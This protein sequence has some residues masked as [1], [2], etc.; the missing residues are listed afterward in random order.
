VE[1]KLKGTLIFGGGT[2]AE[3]RPQP[4]CTESTGE[5]LGPSL[6]DLSVLDPTTTSEESEYWGV[7][8]AELAPRMSAAT[9]LLHTYELRR[10]QRLSA[11]SLGAGG[12]GAAA[13]CGLFKEIGESLNICPAATPAKPS[14]VL[15]L[16]EGCL[17]LGTYQ[18]ARPKPGWSAPFLHRRD[19]T[20]QITLRCCDVD[21][22]TGT[23]APRPGEEAL[24]QFRPCDFVCMATLK[25]RE[26]AAGEVLELEAEGLE[27]WREMR[28]LLG[29]EPRSCLVASSQG[30]K[31]PG[32]RRRACRRQRARN[33]RA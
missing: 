1:G 27:R 19:E 28:V 15:V 21:V 16:H 26:S 30:G 17:L 33:E 3:F 4:S 10:A 20:S 31:G 29:E 18:R 8:P 2:G 14:G 5:S 23:V 25:R 6:A 11:A 24:K 22:A 7:V 12:G 13:L 32:G 9:Q